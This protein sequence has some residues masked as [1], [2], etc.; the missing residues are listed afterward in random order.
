MEEDNDI[1]EMFLEIME[2]LYVEDT[3]GRIR[4]LSK[5]P[6]YAADDPAAN[7]KTKQKER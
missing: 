1:Y 6:R 4:I 2:Q 3:G 5:N 7:T